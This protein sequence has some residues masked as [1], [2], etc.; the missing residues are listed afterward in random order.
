MSLAD[1]A[2]PDL[3]ASQ[4]SCY[5]DKLHLLSQQ[6]YHVT[7]RRSSCDF[8]ANISIRFTSFLLGRADI[9]HHC[10]LLDGELITETEPETQV[11]RAIYLIYDTIAINKFSVTEE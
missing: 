8:L 7:W 4:S 1:I 9:T 5:W 6:L 3:A 11:K 10:T 2:T